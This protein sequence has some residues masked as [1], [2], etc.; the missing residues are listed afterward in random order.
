[1]TEFEQAD[2]RI[3]LA[4]ENIFGVKPRFEIGAFEYRS[5]HVPD[6][7]P[8]FAFDPD[9]TLGLL[10]GFENGKRVFVV[11]PPGSG[12]TSHIE[13]VAARLNWPCLRINLD[14]H[15][16]RAD[17]IG[18]D[19]VLLRDGKQIT[20]FV[21]G[22]LVWAMKRPIAV[23]FDEYD[24]GRADVMFV[25]QRLLE[26]DG[27][28]TLLDKNEVIRPHAAFRLF[29]T[30][31]TIGQGDS[32]GL[33]AG[34]Q[35]INQAQMDRWQLILQLDYMPCDR[36]LVVLRGL[37]P[38]MSGEL[39]AQMVRFA[40]FCRHANANGELSLQVSLRTLTSWAS[41]LQSLGEERLAFR[42]SVMNRCNDL[43]KPVVEE[44]YQRVFASNH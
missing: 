27:R 21:P 4:P 23:I 18:R 32:T 22:M 40:G 12:K 36:E 14:G 6:L 7:D 35:V 15:I 28:F 9:I 39:L 24:A 20:E 42:F 3:K 41:N 33:Y 5:E 31:N 16:T 8:N 2:C 44:F 17:L 25:I 37:F 30:S 34:T 38:G 29:A 26:Q 1:M 19:M 13:Q 10:D 43:D 11:G